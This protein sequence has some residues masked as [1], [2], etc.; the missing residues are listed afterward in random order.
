MILTIVDKPE[1][2]KGDAKLQELLLPA[3]N[4]GNEHGANDKEGRCN[5]GVLKCGHA[6]LAVMRLGG[7]GLG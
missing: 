3:C 6:R 5:N 2:K 1:E 4:V 7:D